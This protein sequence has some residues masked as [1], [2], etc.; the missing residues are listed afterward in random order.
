MQRFIKKFFKKIDKEIWIIFCLS[1]IF[2]YKLFLYPKGIISPA[3]DLQ[4]VYFNMKLF[5]IENITGLFRFPLWYPYNLSG[6]TYVGAPDSAIFSPFNILYLVFPISFAFGASFV[7]NVFLVGAF[8]YLFTRLLK[9]SRFGSLVS[10]IIMMFG[11]PFITL[12][13]PG[14]TFVADTITWIPLLF[15]FYEKSIQKNTLFYGIFAGIIFGFILIAGHFQP[16]VYGFT[17]VNMYLLLRILLSK[18]IKNNLKFIL[19]P[20]ITVTI[21][22][23]LFAVELLPII[24]SIFYSNRSGGLTFEFASD[25]SLPP[26]QLLSFIFPNAF[27]NPVDQTYWGKGNFW[28]LCGYMGIIPVILAVFSLAKKKN[29]YI[30][31]FSFLAFFAVFYSFGKYSFMFPFFYKYVPGFD[32]FRVPSRFLY[33]FGFSISILSGFGVDKLIKLKEDNF[34]IIQR[35]SK[36]TILIIIFLSISIVVL[37]Q[38]GALAFYYEKIAPSSVYGIGIKRS[39]LLNYLLVDF[40]VLS[41]IILGFCLLLMFKKENKKVFNVLILFLILFNSWFYWINYYEVKDLNPIFKKPDVAKELLKDNSDYRVMDLSG[42]LIKELSYLKV[43]ILTGERSTY[44]AFYK[45]FIWLMGDYKYLPFDVY[46]Q[47]YNIKNINILKLLN[48]KYVISKTKLSNNNLELVYK[49]KKYYLYKLTEPFSRAYIVPDKKS[50]KNTSEALRILKN[51]HFQ[52]KN[53][54]LIKNVPIAVN[55]KQDYKE[56]TVIDINSDQI[57]IKPFYSKS[58][59]LVLSEQWYPGWNAY[60]NGKKVKVY[61]TNGILRGLIL[62]EGNHNIVFKYEPESFK[63]G[64]WVSF[65][66][67]IFLSIYLYIRKKKTSYLS[68]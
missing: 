67:V 58:G 25:Y 11:G 19:L 23:L 17:A 65:L 39:I 24:E 63:I 55:S 51:E 18:K 28:S 48:V 37:N 15:Y 29:I 16:G 12:I 33:V 56:L 10:A 3:S 50:V 61:K 32:L 4:N 59:I 35:I 14:H 44:P 46:T 45:E 13:Y 22:F 47:I 64:I 49:D 1:I 6:F 62:N 20:I 57:Q 34:K 68:S 30:L 9:I 66:T 5:F 2:F 43:K 52:I 36:I 40:S 54:A 27:G 42:D 26:K 8:T 53:I 38:S 41:A 7:L 60:D 21:G 31:I